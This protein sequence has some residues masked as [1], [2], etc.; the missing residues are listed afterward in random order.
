MKEGR[1]LGPFQPF[2]LTEMLEEGELTPLDAVWHEGMENWLPLK[3]TDSLRTVLRKG[4]AAPDSDAPALPPP[5][6][7]GSPPAEL[8]IALLRLRRALAWRRFFAKQI[9]L[10]LALT[11][12]AAAA[13]A[14]GWTDM[15]MIYLPDSLLLILAPALLWIVPEAALL[16]LFGTTPG[17]MVL[18]VRVVDEDGK[19]PPF[20][21]ALKRSLLV[22]ARIV[23]SASSTGVPASILDSPEFATANPA[24]F[25]LSLWERVG[26]RDR[27]F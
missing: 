19:P 14:L 6:P 1:R 12:T 15:W 25:S 9:D 23:P 5:L 26:V 4:T 16:S 7:P 27:A 22:W 2:R 20:G 24:V 13:T 10:T 11:I 18:G 17:R 3:D 8:T 21:R